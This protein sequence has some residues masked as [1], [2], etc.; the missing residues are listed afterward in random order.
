MFVAEKQSQPGRFAVSLQLNQQQTSKTVSRQLDH[1][2]FVR[3]KSFHVRTTAVSSKKFKK[4]LFHWVAILTTTITRKRLT[5]REISSVLRKAAGAAQTTASR[6]RCF[7]SFP[8][9]AAAPHSSAACLGIRSPSAAAV[10]QESYPSAQ[11]SGS[12]T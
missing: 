5:G 10:V 3:K 4:L 9:Q 8:L 1:F 7:Q 12:Q 6:S 2:S 11:A